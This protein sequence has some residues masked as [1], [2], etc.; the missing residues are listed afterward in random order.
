[1]FNCEKYFRIFPWTITQISKQFCVVIITQ[2]GGVAAPVGG[3]VFSE[4][5]PYLEVNQGNKEEVEEIE[6]IVTPDLIGKNLNEAEK[7][8]KENGLKLNLQ[9]DY[10]DSNK[11]EIFITEQ[12]PNAGINVKKGSNIYIKCDK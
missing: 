2:G 11:E 3:Q 7:I 8:L 9:N 4:V 12:I 6:Q 10:E 5:L 1:M